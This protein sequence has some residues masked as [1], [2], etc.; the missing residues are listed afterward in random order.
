MRRSRIDTIATALA[1]VAALAVMFVLAHKRKAEPTATVPAWEPPISAP[2]DVEPD[3]DRQ[4]RPKTAGVAQNGR[5]AAKVQV[6]PVACIG[7]GARM[8]CPPP[9]A[10]FDLVSHDCLWKALA[11]ISR[12]GLPDE[13]TAAEIEAGAEATWQF[14]TT[15][16]ARF[17]AAWE[18]CPKEWRR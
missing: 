11:L 15:R 10:R 14:Q 5:R 9:K 18:A 7:D 17:G 4:E 3:E 6:R 12:E 16:P 13:V 1:M 2:V 8:L